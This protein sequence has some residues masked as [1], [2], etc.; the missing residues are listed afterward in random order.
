MSPRPSCDRGAGGLRSEKPPALARFILQAAGGCGSP[1]DLH[2]TARK[3]CFGCVLEGSKV[4][5]KGF[6]VLD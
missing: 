3:D 2:R 1:A 5:C 6:A 4:D